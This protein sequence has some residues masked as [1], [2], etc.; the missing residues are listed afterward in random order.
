M[1]YDHA[2]KAFGKIYFAG[3]TVPESEQEKSS[4]MIALAYPEVN[5]ESLHETA[6]PPAPKRTSK[7]KG[8]ASC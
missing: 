2:V 1:V 5:T 4:E 7:A 3:E 8:K 6:Q